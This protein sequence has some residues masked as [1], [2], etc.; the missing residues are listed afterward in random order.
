MTVKENDTYILMAKFLSGEAEIS[1]IELL[2]KWRALSPGNEQLFRKHKEAWELAHATPIE[3]M[4]PDKEVVWNK[5]INKIEQSAPVMYS[6]LFLYRTVG[7]TATITLL[8]GFSLSF[9]LFP[10]KATE[11]RE[12]TVRTLGGQKS[13]VT[14]P[15]GSTVW[16]NGESSLTYATD[17]Q[18]NNREVKLTG[19]AFFDIIRT[20]EM[21]KVNTGGIQVQVHG[22]AFNV[23][24]YQGDDIQVALLRGHV[25]VHNLESKQLLANL[26]PG[27][28]ASIASQTLET[29]I[30]ACDAEI[31]SLWR[32]GMLKIIDEPMTQVIE[33]MKRWY[34]VNITLKGKS[35]VTDVHYWMTIKTES[36]TEILSLINKTTPIN[37]LI[38]GEEVIIEYK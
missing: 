13:E 2:E 18:A 34:G 14:L 35:K 10:G 3:S 36:L 24:A 22:T 29:N 1:E 5:L 26:S 15:D 7:I 25:T 8:I 37:Y 31:E 21:F 28:K 4:I 19:E 20:D 32:L 27:H 23:N 16:L 11:R 17:F 38:N 33:K 9:L 12:V 30:V 6:R